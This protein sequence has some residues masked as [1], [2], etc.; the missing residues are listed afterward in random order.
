MK[1]LFRYGWVITFYFPSLLLAKA[2]FALP[3]ADISGTTWKGMSNQN[4]VTLTITQLTVNENE[5][6]VITLPEI[7]IEGSA[8]TQP[9]NESDWW[10]EGF[11]QG[12]NSPDTEIERPLMIDDEWAAIFLAGVESGQNANWEMQAEFE[13][14][15]RDSPQIGPYKEIDD[16]AFKEAQERYKEAWEAVFH[17]HMPHTEVEVEP[18][19]PPVRPNTVPVPIRLSK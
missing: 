11:I 4:S 8:N 13:E 5:S 10:C 18:G 17:E 2:A 3:P 16:E 12:F 14:R 6:N 7:T 19:L 15:Y 9:K 1:S